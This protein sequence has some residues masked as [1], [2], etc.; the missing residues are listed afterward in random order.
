[1]TDDAPGIGPC[2]N[3]GCLLAGTPSVGV[4]ELR[5]KPMS[6]SILG[7]TDAGKVY[8]LGKGKVKRGNV[9]AAYAL[10][11]REYPQVSIFPAVFGL[12]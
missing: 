12:Q 3:M 6:K 8:K 5:P 11:E 9:K 2:Q 7:K 10:L 1:M 4:R